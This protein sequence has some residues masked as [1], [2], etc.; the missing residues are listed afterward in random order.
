MQELNCLQALGLEAL[1][2]PSFD[3]EPGQ[4][5]AGGGASGRRSQRTYAVAYTFPDGPRPRWGLRDQPL[6]AAL[7]SE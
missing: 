3:R 4:R 2:A 1:D 5:L 6:V 7:R